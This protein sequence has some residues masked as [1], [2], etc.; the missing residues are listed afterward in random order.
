[1]AR[2]GQ[3]LVPTVSCLYGMAGLGER[4]GTSADDEEY[5]GGAGGGLKRPPMPTWTTLL[6]ELAHHNVEQ[7]ALTIQAA[8]AAGVTMAMGFD[9][10]PPHRSAL[11]LLRLIHMGLTPQEGLISATSGAAI[12]VGLSEHVGTV[13]VGKQAD[14]LVVDGDPLARPELLLERE[15]IWLVTRLGKPVAGTSLERDPAQQPTAA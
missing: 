1:M 2:D 7:A 10:G 6:V 3:V 14:L 8:R 15:S 13:E 4:I 12:A 11:E 9:W 5:Q